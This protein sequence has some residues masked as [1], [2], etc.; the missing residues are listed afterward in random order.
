MITTL[1]GPVVGLNKL[2]QKC[3]KQHS[4][5]DTL[6]RTNYCRPNHEEFCKVSQFKKKI[7]TVQI[8]V[9]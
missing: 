9:H 8:L 1:K 2:Q 6:V 7:A 3:V 5:T 4:V